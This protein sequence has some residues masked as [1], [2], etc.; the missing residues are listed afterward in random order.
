LRSSNHH[1]NGRAVIPTIAQMQPY[2]TTVKR[3]IALQRVEPIVEML[4]QNLA[5]ALVLRDLYKKH[6]W[7]VS[8]PGFGQLQLLFDKHY[9]E[10]EGIA[11]L[12]AEPIQ[13]SRRRHRGH[14][15]GRL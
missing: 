8:G 11:D 5:D 4:N 9:R 14:G 12:F 7:Q 2:G 6:R 1:L 15:I 3:P 13:N 10:L